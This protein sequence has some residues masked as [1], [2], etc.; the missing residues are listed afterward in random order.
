MA[1]TAARQSCSGQESHPETTFDEAPPPPIGGLRNKPTIR[2]PFPSTPDNILK[3]TNLKAGIK[4][5]LKAIA[6]T[7]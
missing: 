4:K 5:D 7:L 3:F 6:K 1:D 2:H